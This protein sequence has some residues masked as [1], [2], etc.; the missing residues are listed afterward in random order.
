[1]HPESRA[2]GGQTKESALTASRLELQAVLGTF[3]CFIRDCLHCT[4]AL[5]LN[6]SD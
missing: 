5:L 2:N 3:V 1:M 4:A 6:K